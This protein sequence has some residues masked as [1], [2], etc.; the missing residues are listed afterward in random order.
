M[1]HRAYRKNFN[2]DFNHKKAMLRN[3][4]VSLVEHGRIKTTL[5]KAKELRRHADRVVTIGKRGGLNSIRLL[6]S[7][8]PNKKMVFDVCE[9]LVGRFQ[10]RKGGYTRIIKLGK[11][12]GDNAEMAF[13]EWVDHL[14]VSNLAKR[15]SRKARETDK[16]AQDEQNKTKRGSTKKN[17]SRKAKLVSKKLRKK[18]QK[19]SGKTTS[20]KKV[21]DKKVSSKKTS[22]KKKQQIAKDTKGKDVKNKDVKSKEVSNTKAK[23]AGAKG[24]KPTKKKRKLSLKKSIFGRLRKKKTK[25]S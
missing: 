2:R 12:L 25:K 22:S 5:A 15:D 3:L 13:I 11:R 1:R 10:D 17:K 9:N 6:L 14:G 19:T 7:K 8:Y 23:V 16:S 20:S 18:A 24:D 4:V 21:S